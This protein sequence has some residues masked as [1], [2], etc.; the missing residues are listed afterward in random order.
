LLHDAPVEPKDAAKGFRAGRGAAKNRKEV[1]G[2]IHEDEKTGRMLYAPKVWTD[3]TGVHAVIEKDRSVMLR[4]R[5]P[6]ALAC[7]TLAGLAL[8]VQPLAAQSAATDETRQRLGREYRLVEMVVA[9]QELLLP[10][11]APITL[12]WVS[13]SVLAG[14]SSINFYFASVDLDG[15]GHIFWRKPG[16][17]TTLMAGSPELMQLEQGFLTALATTKS[18]RFGE[19]ELVFEDVEAAVRLTFREV[20]SDAARQALYGKPLFLKRMIAG[21][22]EA[23]LPA[24][25]EITLVLTESGRIAGRATVNW[26]FGA[27]RQT[28]NGGFEAGQALGSTRMAGPPEFMQAETTYLRALAAAE[29]MRPNADGLTLENTAKTVVLDFELSR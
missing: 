22:R 26:Y 19:A 29:R 5:K 12:K 24:G 4:Q 14:K 23:P 7:I 15:Q 25:A 11:Q 13:E 2:K 10:E 6:D 21:G 8:T 20:D 3:E 16:F 1:E 18:V 28:P 17:A 27:F 9:A